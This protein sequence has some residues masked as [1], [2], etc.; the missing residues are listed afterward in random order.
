ML[1]LLFTVQYAWHRSRTHTMH[2]QSMQLHAP[3]VTLLLAMSS[4]SGKSKARVVL[5]RAI[6]SLS[7]IFSSKATAP[8]LIM[9]G[10]NQV[11]NPN[12]IETQCRNAPFNSHSYCTRA[13]QSASLPSVSPASIAFSRNHSIY[14]ISAP[15]SSQLHP[16]F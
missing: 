3:F 15:L 16:H 7:I 5:C 12:Q 10:P 11:G 6:P 9:T 2:R 8:I 14:V 4:C 1:L 13:Q